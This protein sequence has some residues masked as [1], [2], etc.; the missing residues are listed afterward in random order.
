MQ[1]Q[2]SEANTAD[3]DSALEYVYAR[4]KQSYPEAHVIH[5]RLFLSPDKRVKVGQIS[6]RC[7]PVVL[8]TNLASLV[9]QIVGPP[10]DPHQMSAGK[11]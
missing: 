9:S 2:R 7:A 4:V 6:E 5:K 1:V 11:S 8:S 3:I 10:L